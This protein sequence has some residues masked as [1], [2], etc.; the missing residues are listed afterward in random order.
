MARRSLKE[1]Y[2]ENARKERELQLIEQGAWELSTERARQL[3]E[4]EEERDD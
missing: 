3:A 2:R 1:F 4:V